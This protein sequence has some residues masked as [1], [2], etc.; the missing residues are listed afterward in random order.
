MH[1]RGLK[2]EASRVTGESSGERFSTSTS[3]SRVE[4]EA[5]DDARTLA[6]LD[7]SLIAFSLLLL[8]LSWVA[9][10]LTFC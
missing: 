6:L 1:T 5:G 10:D 9:K 3:G 4:K 7:L 2:R 8:L